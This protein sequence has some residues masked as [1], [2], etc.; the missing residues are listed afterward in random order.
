MIRLAVAQLRHRGLRYLSLFFSIFAAVALTVATA[1]ITT[2]LQ[3][4]VG[5]IFDKPYA[6]AD[7]VVTVRNTDRDADPLTAIRAVPGVADA[8]FDQT[9]RGAVADT[10][11]VYRSTYIQS[12][13]DGPLQWRSL[14]EGR[15]PAADDEVLA[16]DDD[17][18]IGQELSLEAPGIPDPTRVRIV[19]RAEK[20][21]QEQ[22]IGSESILATPA[23]VDAWSGGSRTGE[24][25]VMAVPGT[26]PEA[27]TGA[28]RAA[29]P[30]GSSTSVTTATAHTAELSDRYLS[31]RDRYFLLLAV[32]IAVV[33]AVAGLVILSAFSVLTGERQ[34]EFALLR[35]T[36]AS[37]AQIL[38]SVILEA[39]ILGVLAGVLGAPAGLWLARIAGT[40]ADVLGVRVPLAD[41]TLSGSWQAIIVFLGV[42]AAV[43]AALPAGRSVVRR[44]ITQS[45]ASKGVSQQSAPRRILTFVLGAATTAAGLAAATVVPGL[46][47]KRAVVGSVGA[48]I[49]IALG[50]L[51][52]L[53]V[54]LPALINRLSRVM[55]LLPVPTLQ[56]GAAFV[57]RQVQRSGA[58]VAIIF[59]GVT[60]VAAVLHGQDIIR[61]HLTAGARGTSDIDVTVTALED[62]IPDELVTAIRNTDGVAAAIAPSAARVDNPWGTSENVLTLD[63][64][65]GGQLLR[66]GMG[67]APGEIIVGDYSPIRDRVREGRQVELTIFDQPV[68]ATV[69]HGT[70]RT[71]FIA[72]DLVDGARARSL[73]TKGVP[74]D[75]APPL[76]RPA[77]LIRTEGPPDQAA[78]NPTLNAISA[79]IAQNGS[80]VSVAESFSTR[81][82]IAATTD[83]ILTM[84]TLMTLVAGLIAGVGVANTV[85]LAVRER[86]RDRELLGA[87][88]MSRAGQMLM[89]LTEVTVLAIPAALIAAIAG[90]VLGTWVGGI[91]TS[92]GSHSGILTSPDAAISGT[93]TI[94]ALLITCISALVAA[95]R[96]HTRTT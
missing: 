15:F 90:G 40:N 83:R 73:E 45:L 43:L 44:P 85:T 2:T 57:G 69:R 8:V 76:P 63:Q 92:G 30:Q 94:S 11:T 12:V 86:A 89:L 61:D 21:A 50:V 53:A 33:A 71:S 6:N 14:T 96:G 17:H 10:G 51:I 16:T 72:P 23:A 3:R 31:K 80:R 70:G 34:R 41:V 79:A 19:G 78:D 91:A 77:I 88:G 26:T 75:K 27:L 20:S 46:T 52:M 7:V 56:L 42:M 66:G 95:G 81:A 49:L 35:S 55:G 39:T 54:L 68:T 4:T 84:S 74:G 32:F 59:A 25:R 9:F 62:S 48:A 93:L 13:T 38:V 60:L 67:A 65:A 87:L 1:A 47:A 82:E 37:T 18:A 58:L 28:I 36:G 5:E 64:A 24:I 22:L 29:L